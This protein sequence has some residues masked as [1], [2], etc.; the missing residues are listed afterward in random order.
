MSSESHGEL[1]RTVIS[2]QNRLIVDP[3]T[4]IYVSVWSVK[5]SYLIGVC[6]GIETFSSPGGFFLG[7]ISTFV[8][9][10]KKYIQLTAVKWYDFSSEILATKVDWWAT[11]TLLL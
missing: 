2:I 6:G 9:E 7:V 3:Q 11:P 5:R 4:N 10:E 8:L 1:Q